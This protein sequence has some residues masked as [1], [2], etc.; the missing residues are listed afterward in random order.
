MDCARVAFFNEMQTPAVRVQLPAGEAFEAALVEAAAKYAA[1]RGFTDA[2][3]AAFL[4]SVEAAVRAVSSAGPS[5][6]T[7]SA[8]SDDATVDATVSGTDATAAMSSA[9]IDEARR[10]GADLRAVDADATG[11]TVRIV[12]SLD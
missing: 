2:V 1:R 10:R 8:T 3:E 11:A 5:A 9:L 4:A 12:A 6:I 7:L